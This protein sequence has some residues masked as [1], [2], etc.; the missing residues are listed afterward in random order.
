MTPAGWAAAGIAGLITLRDHLQDTESWAHKTAKAMGLM[1]AE[2]NEARK[3]QTALR[4]AEAA[5]ADEKSLIEQV[6]KLKEGQAKL[7]KEQGGD[8]GSQWAQGEE[9]KKQLKEIETK[10]QNMPALQIEIKG[11]D[12]VEKYTETLDGLKKKKE[13]IIESRK[14]SV[15]HFEWG[16]TLAN[17]DKEIKKNEDLI[18]VRKKYDTM[19]AN[20][21]KPLTVQETDPREQAAAAPTPA[22]APKGKAAPT[23]V[24]GM[25]PTESQKL[26]NELAKSLEIVE[27][28]FK[29]TGDEEDRLR[30]KSKHLK[31]ALDDIAAVNDDTAKNILTK[32]GQQY[33]ENEAALDKYTNV[34][35]KA[36]KDSNDFKATT[37]AL[38]REQQLLGVTTESIQTELNAYESRLREVLK[39]GG[40]NKTEVASLTAKIKELQTALADSKAADAQKKI[41]ET[42]NASFDNAAIHGG[43]YADKVNAIQQRITALNTAHRALIK[44]LGE[45][46]PAVK[47][48]ADRIT[49][50]EEALAQAK[51]EEKYA[52]L[53]DKIKLKTVEA[54]EEFGALGDTQAY[55]KSQVDIATF[56][57]LGMYKIFGEGSPQV[58]QARDDLISA[59]NAMDIWTTGK[60][61]LDAA[62]KV[63]DKNAK[64]EEKVWKK[65]ADTIMGVSDQIGEA[66]GN[67]VIGVKTTKEEYKQTLKEL[68]KIIIKFVIQAV[69]QFIIL[70]IVGGAGGA[71]GTIGQRLGQSFSTGLTGNFVTSM[72]AKAQGG[73]LTRP[74]VSRLA[75]RGPEAVIPL[76]N[77]TVPVSIYG[78]MNTGMDMGGPSDHPFEVTIINVVEKGKAESM[79]RDKKAIINTINEDLESRG[80]VY[81]SVKGVAK[82]R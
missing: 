38:T 32:V 66:L 11:L 67:M 53:M 51:G 48:L 22:P 62:M 30:E 36:I 37:A 15:I 8:P 40:D 5:G 80:S 10:Y 77:G 49:A 65:L 35:K 42:L 58:Q 2:A 29:A 3:A 73:V 64:E 21:P 59:A 33:K 71:G 19:V 7:A 14:K 75:E 16:N 39:A 45:T 23:A 20:P 81:R 26:Y 72:P 25:P 31:K 68:L 74:T 13:E 24:A 28:K 6:R 69:A 52:D 50:E 82:A 55:L 34:T 78:G 17:I 4:Q 79:A 76:Q 70:S 54:E 12:T 43:T 60:T 41:M 1:R 63:A 56:S 61:K 47:S 9:I 44:L 27:K 18:V 57:L 46:S